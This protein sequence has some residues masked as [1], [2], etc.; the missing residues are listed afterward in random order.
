[1]PR[2]LH[3]LGIGF[4]LQFY[5]STK[6]IMEVL[7]ELVLGLVAEGNHGIALGGEEHGGHGLN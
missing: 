3:L 7:Q 1:V 2:G 4:E 6:L 5:D